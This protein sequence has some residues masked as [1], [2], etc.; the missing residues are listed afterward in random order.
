MG[1]NFAIVFR[2]KPLAIILPTNAAPRVPIILFLLAKLWV[3]IVDSAP[4]K[5]PP[6]A[7]FIAVSNP[8]LDAKLKAAPPSIAEIVK[9]FFLEYLLVARLRTISHY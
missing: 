6:N 2:P 8:V 1:P 4:A 7:A 5:F 9:L 3:W